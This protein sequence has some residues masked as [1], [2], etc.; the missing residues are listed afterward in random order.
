MATPAAAITALERA[1]RQKDI[2]QSLAS[3]RLEGLEPTDDAKVIFQRYVD[4]KI[5][6][7]GMIEEIR[8]LNARK[9]GPVP[10]SGH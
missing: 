1:E 9:Y 6:I 3:V 8:I 10:V 7:D 2:D 5:D 4:G